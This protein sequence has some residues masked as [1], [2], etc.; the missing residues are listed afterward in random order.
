[1][2]DNTFALMTSEITTKFIARC[3]EY[4]QA[5]CDLHDKQALIIKLKRER[6]ELQARIEMEHAVMEELI[7]EL[8]NSR[9]ELDHAAAAYALHTC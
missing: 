2:D 7:D 3:K 9:F 8:N 1:M 6:D 5:S 4:K